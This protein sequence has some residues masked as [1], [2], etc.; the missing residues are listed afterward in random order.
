MKKLDDLVDDVLGLHFA[1]NVFIASIAVWLPFTLFTTIDPI[2]SMASMVA[3]SE[4]LPKKGFEMF[5]AR[6]INTLVGCAVGITFLAVG[7]PRPWKLPFALAVTVLLSSYVVRITTMWRQAP[8]TAAIVISGG[9][10]SHSTMNGLESGLRRVGEVLF[11]C[12][13]ALAV[14]FVMAR[15]WPVVPNE[16]KPPAPGGGPA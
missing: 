14:S 13:V 12:L 10:Y 11:G 8:I 9:I 15:L 1:L 4:P 3:A 5:R 6:L 7:D 16:P 2:W